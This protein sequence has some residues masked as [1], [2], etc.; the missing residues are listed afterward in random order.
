[1][2]L[3]LEKKFMMPQWM[4]PPRKWSRTTSNKESCE[5]QRAMS[6]NITESREA[7]PA[8]QSDP[9]VEPTPSVTKALEN[10]VEITAMT[11]EGGE[12]KTSADLTPSVTEALESQEETTEVSSGVDKAGSIVE[13]APSVTEVQETLEE[14][15]VKLMRVETDERHDQGE[16]KW[17]LPEWFKQRQRESVARHAE[18]RRS[19]MRLGMWG[20]PLEARAQSSMC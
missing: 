3:V 11:S 16:Q 12:S 9:P 19:G 14:A 17:E 1:M 20:F 6:M 4:E 5:V 2:S 10:A 13:P 15:A 7:E 8:T 18:R